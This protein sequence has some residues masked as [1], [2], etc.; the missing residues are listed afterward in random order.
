MKPRRL[1]PGVN[2]GLYAY[3]RFRCRCAVC[4]QARRDYVH[5]RR[6]PVVS[7]ERDPGDHR[8]GTRYAYVD[9]GC[10]C[11]RC[12][13]ANTIHQAGRRAA[14]ARMRMEATFDEL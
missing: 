4:V 6:H 11:G 5:K 12:T 14:A 13:A 10:R 1:P 7:L 2:H 9:L 3:T 8:H